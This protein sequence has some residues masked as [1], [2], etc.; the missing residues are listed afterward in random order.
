MVAALQLLHQPADP[1][2]S[3]NQSDLTNLLR[4]E[5]T[6]TSLEPPPAHLCDTTHGARKSESMYVLENLCKNTVDL[7]RDENLK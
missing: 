5:E 2:Q 4:S 7:K 1:L 3:L 6:P